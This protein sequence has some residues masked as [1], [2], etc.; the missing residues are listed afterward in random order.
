MRASCAGGA[1]IRNHHVVGGG[2]PAD[3]DG[4]VSIRVLPSV[5]GRHYCQ[6]DWHVI[7]VA[8]ISGGD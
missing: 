1:A 4:R 7:L 8:E 2:S 3:I 5:D 6:D